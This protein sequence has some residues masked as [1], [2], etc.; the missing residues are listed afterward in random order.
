MHC[1]RLSHLENAYT[2]T[3]THTH[4]HIHYVDE[5]LSGN[6]RSEGSALQEV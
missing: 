5:I 2:H 6:G 1:V 4:T 3:H